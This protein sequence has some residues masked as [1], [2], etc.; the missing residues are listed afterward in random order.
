MS[1]A[2]TD[3]PLHR[4][5][6][7]AGAN[8]DDCKCSAPSAG[9]LGSAAQPVAARS[10]AERVL[11]LARKR[12]RHGVHCSDFAVAGNT[13]DGG[14]PILRLA[15]RIDELRLRGHWFDTRRRRDR[16]VDYILVRD[17]ATVELALRE[18]GEPERLFEPA[19]APLNAALID[20]EAAWA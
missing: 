13:A 11:E 1:S 18:A 4:K 10:G 2:S 14:K 8:A 19:P 15:A 6:A 5:R 7:P 12:G 20:W 3:P 16:T 9:H 17:A